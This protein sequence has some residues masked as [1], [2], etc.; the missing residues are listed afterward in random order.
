MPCSGRE[1][2]LAG[3]NEGTGGG[4]ALPLGMGGGLDENAE[5]FLELWP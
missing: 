4:S 5:K 3:G 2:T 1:R